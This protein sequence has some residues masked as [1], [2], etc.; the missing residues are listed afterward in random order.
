[1]GWDGASGGGG[2][3][4]VGGVHNEYTRSPLTHTC[5]QRPGKMACAVIVIY[6]I[7]YII[8]EF[9]VIP[10]EKTAESTT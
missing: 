7:N 5:S 9:I 4:V 6:I 2:G 10:L 8:N 3:G 1:M